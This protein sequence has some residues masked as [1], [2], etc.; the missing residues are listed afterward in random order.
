MERVSVLFVAFKVP[1]PKSVR[2]LFFSRMV[3]IDI[4]TTTMRHTYST[5][6]QGNTYLLMETEAKIPALISRIKKFHSLTTAAAAAAA[7]R[8]KFKANIPGNNVK[9]DKRYKACRAGAMCVALRMRLWFLNPAKVEFSSY[10][11]HTRRQA[12]VERIRQ[13][14]FLFGFF[15]F[16]VFPSL[17]FS[18]SYA[19]KY[20]RDLRTS[21]V[22]TYIY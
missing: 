6:A 14:H 11:S 5:C 20:N 4:L 18:I 3:F 10:Q 15:F 7:N 21:Y 8:R 1:T 22:Y 9:E 19:Y 17:H 2:P 16:L 12:H 13:F